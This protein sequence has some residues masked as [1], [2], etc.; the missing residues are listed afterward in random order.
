M[1]A[2]AETLSQHCSQVFCHLI[3]SCFVPAL[4][5]SFLL[6]PDVPWQAALLTAVGIVLCFVALSS[7]ALK[8]VL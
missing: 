1:N 4:C 2:A 7:A 3:H 5:S 6:V 8:Q